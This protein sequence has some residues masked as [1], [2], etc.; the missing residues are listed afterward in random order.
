MRALGHGKGLG[1]SGNC[2]EASVAGVW[3]ECGWQVANKGWRVDTEGRAG[4]AGQRG[5]FSCSL[6]CKGESPKGF[7]NGVM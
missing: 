5:K 2:L 3:L 4:L 7:K 6:K 1:C